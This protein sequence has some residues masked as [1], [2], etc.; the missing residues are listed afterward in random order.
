MISSGEPRI[1]GQHTGMI[2]A[3]ALASDAQLAL[4]A[5]NDKTLKIWDVKHC[6][7]VATF[8]VEYPL[9]CCT[10]APNGRTIAA[11]DSFGN[12][13]ILRLQAE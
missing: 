9:Q 12:V 4:S 3:V 1:L 10:F 6:Q 8:T 13:H 5:S 7:H 11:G 2:T